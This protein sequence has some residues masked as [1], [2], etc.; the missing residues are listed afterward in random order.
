MEYNFL[1]VATFCQRKYQFFKLYKLLLTDD[2]FRELSSDAKIAYSLFE[3][4]HQSSVKNPDFKD[5][6]GKSFIL[7]SRT[8][9]VNALNCS[10][11]KAAD[12]MKELINFGLIE[13]SKK[14]GGFD[15]KKNSG[16]YRLYVRDYVDFIKSK[17]QK[18]KDGRFDEISSRDFYMIPYDLFDNRKEFFFLSTNI[19]ISY[20][21]LLNLCVLS[22]ENEAYQDEN[23]N[24]FVKQSIAEL[25]EIFGGEK[26]CSISTA[27]RY[28]E[29][30]ES[31]GL[32]LRKRIDN[33]T[34]IYVKNF[35][36]PK[37]VKTCTTVGSEPAQQQGQ[38][39]HNSEV[40]TC[41]TVGSKPAQQQAQNLHNSEV[42]TCTTY[43]KTRI[44]KSRLNLTR[45]TKGTRLIKSESNDLKKILSSLR[46]KLEID[47]LILYYEEHKSFYP[48][49]AEYS[50]R[51]IKL[52]EQLFEAITF[53]FSTKHS[54]LYLSGNEISI[55][56]IRVHYLNLE[57]EDIDVIVSKLADSHSEVAYMQKYMITALYNAVEEKSVLYER[58]A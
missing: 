28:Y 48:Q 57:W 8:E 12:I 42:K 31:A 33:E 13:R 17:K 27:K 5:S 38:N 26:Y 52:I 51:A 34:Q 39:L 53:V 54:T 19:K 20:S 32:I 16:Q 41:T 58:E 29:K 36:S 44:N 22:Y 1:N 18:K 40:K 45:L 21:V 46:E 25:M 50:D 10:T 4:R 30:L 2:S 56:D 11:H 23:G 15:H 7:F 49:Y 6:D 47:D 35:L 24:I 9:L 55:A 3:N 43:L 37:E 14:L